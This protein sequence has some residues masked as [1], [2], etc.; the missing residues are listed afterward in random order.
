[1]SD[2]WTYEDKR[3]EAERRKEHEERMEA[4]RREE[5]RQDARPTVHPKELDI[6]ESSSMIDTETPTDE[7]GEP[8]FTEEGT[9]VIEGFR[10]YDEGDRV[11]IHTETCSI[12]GEITET[13]ESNGGFWASVNPTDLDQ[14]EHCIGAPVDSPIRVV[15]T[16]PAEAGDGGWLVPAT[17]SVRHNDVLESSGALGRVRSIEAGK[18]GPVNVLDRF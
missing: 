15:L 3:I 9:E 14:V 11:T 4:D 7:D 12:N 10:T 6:G 16:I 18:G 5:I 2:D 13:D 17:L 1:M 8:L